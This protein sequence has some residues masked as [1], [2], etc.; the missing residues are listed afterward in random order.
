MNKAPYPS[1]GDKRIKYIFD[2][3]NDIYKTY[4]IYKIIQGFGRSTRHENDYSITFCLD[5][6]LKRLFYDKMNY[7]KNEFNI[8]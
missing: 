7:W 3:Y 1:L 4:T 8:I 5:T 2:N 6:N